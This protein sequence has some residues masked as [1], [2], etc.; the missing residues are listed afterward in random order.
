MSK[1]RLT[2]DE[3]IKLITSV[4][5]GEVDEDTRSSFLEYI[6]E[7]KEVRAEYESLKRIKQLV[8]ERC[9]T[10][11]APETLKLRVQQFLSEQQG[12]INNINNPK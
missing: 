6:S 11:R 9:P 2:K 5:D 1:E 12:N 10:H 3:A 8:V 7:D 4:V